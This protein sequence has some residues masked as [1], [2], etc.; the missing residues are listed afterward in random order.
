MSQQCKEQANAVDVPAQYLAS[1]ENKQQPLR[2]SL[3]H[4]HAKVLLQN[5]QQE[6][7]LNTANKERRCFT[8]NFDKRPTRGDS[9]SS[10]ENDILSCKTPIEKNARMQALRGVFA[11]EVERA[12]AFVGVVVV[13]EGRS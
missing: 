4:M 5:R 8:K 2:R 10:L 9:L 7:D 6:A 1:T 13:P 3:F 11:L 12:E